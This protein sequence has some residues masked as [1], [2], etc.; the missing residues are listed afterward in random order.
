M[1][2]LK[3][4]FLLFLL[5]NNLFAYTLKQ[6]YITQKDA[7]YASD[8]LKDV[9]KDFLLFNYE[10][11]RHLL[12]VPANEVIKTFKEHGYTIENQAVRYVN[13]KE[14][15]PVDL[16]R[17]HD[18]LYKA[19]L[20]KYPSIKIQSL[21]IYPRA[22][23]STLPKDYT[24]SIPSQALY[25]SYSVISIL[26]PEHK[27]IFFDYL[28]DATLDTIMTTKEIKRHEA[29][30]INNTKIKNIKFTSFTDDP[31]TDITNHKYQSKF[32]LK[33]DFILTQNNVEALSVVRR[34]DEIAATITDGGVVVSLS[35]VAQQD[36]RA[37]DIITVKTSEGK[38]LKAQVVGIKR[39]EIQ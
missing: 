6:D 39:V 5:G 11:D 4:I 25:K 31:L 18:E 38:K 24:L 7:V 2:F 37:G 12:R 22:Y 3:Y 13:F 8:I 15:S 23:L 10:V 35:V 28:L 26:T 29:L 27:M 17:I 14:K 36:G 1:S 30:G 34:G 21:E 33:S 9:D 20:E 32:S 16:S 19:F